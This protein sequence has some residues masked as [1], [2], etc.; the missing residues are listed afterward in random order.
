ML[1]AIGS[2]YVALGVPERGQALL[3]EAMA[4]RRGRGKPTPLR[5]A[6]T[7]NRLAE[8][9]RERGKDTDAEPLARAALEIRRRRGGPNDSDVASSLNNLAQI[10]N[11]RGST[12]EPEALYLESIA[13][14]R[15]ARRAETIHSWPAR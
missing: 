7:M 12:A 2:V 1:D 11:K 8:A 5:M 15:A 14:W 13:I 10:R 9:L 4:L 3:D 6:R